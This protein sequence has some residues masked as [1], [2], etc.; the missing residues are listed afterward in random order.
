VFAVVVGSQLPDLVDKPL[1]WT[2]EVL[3]SG[4]SL[5]HSLFAVVAVVTLTYWVSQRFQ[6]E[7]I[8]AWL[9]LGMV[10]HSFV[11]LG[12]DVMIGLLQGHWG[13]LQWT[14]YLLWPLLAAPPYPNDDSFM[15]HFL[16]LALDQYVLLQFGL[17]AVAAVVWF[18]SDAPGYRFIQHQIRTR[19]HRSQP[20]KSK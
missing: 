18:R 5:M 20:D 3:P 7:E 4:R 16:A 8:T 13:Q 12:P 6:R 17:F 2:F 9:G 14:T 11:D 15:Q 19:F 10:S 1:A